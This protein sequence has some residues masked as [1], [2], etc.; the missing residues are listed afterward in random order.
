[1]AV[2]A[3]IGRYRIDGVLGEGAMAVVY[4][5]FDPQIERPVAIKCLHADVAA[6]PAYRRRFLAEARAAGHLSHP[7][8]VT[9]FDVGETADGR[10]YIAMERLPGVTLAARVASEGMPPLPVLIELVRQ[11]AS[12]LDYAHAQ[13]VVHHDIKPDNVIVSDGWQQAKINDFGIAERPATAADA[14]SEIG[15][16]PAYMAPE[17]LRG[18]A[19]DSRSDL[20]SLGVVLYWLLSGAL[21]WPDSADV[22]ALL[23]LRQGTPLPALQSRDPTTP[24]MLIDIVHTLLDP[25]PSARYQRGSEL[26]A[27]LRLAR[28]EYERQRETPLV[29]RLLSLRV[30]WAGLL[31]AVLCVTLLVGLAAIH[32]RQNAA[33]T[34]LALDFGSSMG[35]MIASESAENLLLGDR[36]ATRALVQD[37]ARN[38]QIHYLAIANRYGE[39]IASTRRDQVGGKLATPSG[40]LPVAVAGDIAS[41]RLPDSG[42]GQDGMLLFDVPVRYQTA[43]VGA[44]RLGVSSAP[45]RAAQRTTL[46]VIAAVLALTLLAV[47]GMAWWLSRRLLTL[48]DLITDGLLRLARGETRHRIRLVRRDELG[49]LFAAFNVMAGALQKRPG[50]IAPAAPATDAATRPTRILPVPASHG[51]APDTAK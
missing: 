12:A 1:M 19:S 40:Q 14:R 24:S 27:D 44:L 9:I 23:L 49:R 43:A 39:V 21:P 7:H 2:P 46:G 48:L 50:P 32:A 51:A 15:G 10:A 17:Q 35:R 31:G 8:I 20:F 45:L 26:I 4:A 36:P 6:D 28:R 25:L 22:P 11:L 33:I 5:A 18:E 37:M 47:V 38:E 34:G 42:S 13:G 29:N 41:Y 3:H 30:R 16:T